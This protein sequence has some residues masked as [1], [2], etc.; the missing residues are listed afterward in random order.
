MMHSLRQET[1]MQYTRFSLLLASALAFGCGGKTD[2]RLGTE[3]TAKP[4]IPIASKHDPKTVGTIRGRVTWTGEV[5]NPPKLTAAIPESPGYKFTEMPN[6]YAPLVSEPGRGL[7]EAVISLEGVNLEAS[8]SWT[9][10]KVLVELSGYRIQVKQGDHRPRRSGFV[11]VGGQ[12]EFVS[13]DSIFHSLRARGAAFFALPF[14]EPEKPLSRKLDKAGLVELTS[15]SGYHWAAADLYV[16]EHPY[17][18]IT[19]DD[20]GFELTAVPPGE[21][22]LIVRVRNWNIVGR[23][24]DPESGLVFKL[25][26]APSVEKR[27][28]ITI[29][30]G[31]TAVQDFQFSTADFPI[32]APKP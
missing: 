26:F 21:Y 3:S 2:S 9:D 10:S 28:H 11:P 27:V 4:P 8:T 20:G 5:P 14:P 30:S 25:I 32:H 13:H 24:R 16:V 18:T 12:V 19:N 29:S 23:E 31:N 22:Q 7:S 17:F 6:P 15:G 1:T